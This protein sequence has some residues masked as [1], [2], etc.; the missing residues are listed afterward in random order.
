M[1]GLG[2]I[3]L[4][5]PSHYGEAYPERQQRLLG[6]YIRLTAEYMKRQDMTVLNIPGDVATLK[7]FCEESPG[8]EGIFVGYGPKKGFDYD[9][10]HRL[11]A[12]VPVFYDLIEST[13][14]T[15]RGLPVPQQNRRKARQ[16][17][18]KLQ[19]V[20]VTERP[21]F[22]YVWTIGWDWG[23]TTLGMVV[24]E[25]GPEYVVVRPDHLCALYAQWREN[26]DRQAAEIR[27]EPQDPGWAV[28]APRLPVQAHCA[29]GFPEAALAE[30]PLD[31]W[32]RFAEAAGADRLRIVACTPDGAA[33]T[34]V[35][36]QLVTDGPA[37]RLVWP[38]P[39][40][41][42]TRASF[43]VY[44]AE[45]VTPVP[46]LR[47]EQTGPEE[48]VLDTGRLRLRLALGGEDGPAP[49]LEIA[50]AD[51]DWLGLGRG[52]GYSAR[53]RELS[54]F[55]CRERVGRLLAEYEYRY[56]FGP[57][58]T[59][60]VKLTTAAGLPY[61]VIEET[62]DRM[63]LP[64]WSFDFAPNLQ[65][66]RLTTSGGAQSLGFD[67]P[68]SRG[69]LPDYAWA[70][71]SEGNDGPAAGLI[72]LDEDQWT[73]AGAVFWTLPGPSAYCEFYGDKPGTRKLALVALPELDR[74]RVRRL[75][76]QLNTPVQVLTGTLETP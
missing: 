41:E 43:C 74:E 9:R 29:S 8:L 18:E 11:S 32:P 70:L 50:P 68:T 22:L 72:A 63:D 3:C 16:L 36:W 12:G 71:L 69:S 2:G 53:K 39:A 26:R 27:Y 20:E 46:G 67:S 37:R 17:L 56:Q 75:W 60:V 62:T 52:V 48:A 34:E 10:S 55:E 24:A 5:E 47:R 30:M 58:G 14:G 7:R 45:P 35:P 57:Y 40:Q 44:L 31:G 61:A 38:V 1:A 59:R 64:S 76:R 42:A 49:V 28:D 65:P 51:G 33:G 19:A 4:G 25:L 23:P 15:G 66:D 54:G 73:A 21:G 13:V 6:D